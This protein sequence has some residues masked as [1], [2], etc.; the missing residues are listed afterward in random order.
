MKTD[1]GRALCLTCLVCLWTAA[2]A[3]AQS[4]PTPQAPPAEAAPAVP[5]APAARAVP[6]QQSDRWE[7]VTATHWRLTGNVEMGF[8]G[9]T[10]KFFADEVDLYL[11]TNSL[12]A[13]GNVVFADT[14][15]RIAADEVEFDIASG[16]GTFKNASGSMGLGD[17]AN[18]SQ[19]GGQDPDVYFYGEVVE[20]Q[21]PRRYKLT[22]GAF[23]TCVQPTPRW[24]VTGRSVT[25]NLDDH[26]YARNMVLK[27]KGVPV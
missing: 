14:D 25:I 6:D 19:F 11:D 27:V 13:K 3:P 18:A 15:G 7:Q 4:Q 22:R 20:K 24:E 5:A 9:S 8:P 23:T 26:A 17:Q 10:F 21:G 16:V 12:V 1:I 2:A